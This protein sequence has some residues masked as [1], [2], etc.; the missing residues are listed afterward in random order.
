MIIKLRDKIF[1]HDNSFLIRNEK[2]K[3]QHFVS[4]VSPWSKDC[5]YYLLVGW[6][7]AIDRG[8]SDVRGSYY[9]L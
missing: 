9:E 6:A 1:A 3:P 5:Y 4:G 7:S 8:E 2:T